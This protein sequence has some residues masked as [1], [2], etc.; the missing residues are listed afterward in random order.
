MKHWQVGLLCVAAGGAMF[1]LPFAIRASTKQLTTQEKSLS[2]SQ[3]QRG[4]YM[5]A[6]S[7]DAGADPDWDPVE[8][9]WKGHRT[10]TQVPGR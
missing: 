8:K 1:G 5:N 7:S 6:G 4:M 2:G 3:R 9:K 10:K